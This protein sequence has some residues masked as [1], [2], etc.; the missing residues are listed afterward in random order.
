MHSSV[1]TLPRVLNPSRI[2][3][4]SVF[5]SASS[6]LAH[7]IVEQAQPQE[8]TGLELWSLTCTRWL[9]WTPSPSLKI[10]PGG[11]LALDALN[12]GSWCQNCGLCWSSTGG[13]PGPWC[14][15]WQAGPMLG[16]CPGCHSSQTDL[17]TGAGEV[18]RWVSDTEPAFMNW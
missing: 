8:V 3:L 13:P 17:C 5:G 10:P 9:L 11:F 12:S 14:H 15:L 4:D 7:F 16:R 1:T 6:H 18:L 2:K